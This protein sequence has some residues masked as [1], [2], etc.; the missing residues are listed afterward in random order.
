MVMVMRVRIIAAAMAAAWACTAL[1]AGEKR[2]QPLHVY[3]LRTVRAV[4]AQLTLGDLG[5]IRGDAQ[6]CR[7]A[8]AVA[9]GRA[10]FSGETVVIDRP[11][12]LSRLAAHGFAAGVVRLTGARKVT[13]SRD[14]KIFPA[15]E[16]LKAAEAF[17]TRRRP[18]PAGCG[19]RLV[20]KVSSP[21][22]SPAGDGKVALRVSLD[23]APPPG[24]VKLRVSAVSGRSELASRELLFKLTY[25]HRQAVTKTPVPAGRKI[26]T[27]NTTIRT[28]RRDSP[29]KADWTAPFGTVATRNLKAGAV[30][31]ATSVR[32]PRAPIAVRRNR[33]VIMVVRGFGFIVT[34]KGLALQDGRPGQFIRVRNVDSQR[35]VVAMVRHDGTVEPSAGR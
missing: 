21:L 15:A 20:T 13:V 5:I 12:V 32:A 31:A 1:A 27:A 23:D 34:A 22:A 19:W 17:L 30:L 33:P 9:M 35:I 14:E 7:K 2:Q 4:G 29:P 11:M 25:P 28:V 6:D 8:G 24:H 18:G 16:L 10:P 26:T 3:L